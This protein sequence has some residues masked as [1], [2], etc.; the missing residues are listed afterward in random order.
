MPRPTP[1]RFRPD[2]NSQRRRIRRIAVQAGVGPLL[3]WQMRVLTGRIP[4]HAA[5][6]TPALALIASKM[7]E[8]PDA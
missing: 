6:M 4:R 3:P 8:A 1:R 7:Q 2:T 5:N